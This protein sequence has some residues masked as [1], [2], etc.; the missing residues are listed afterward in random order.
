MKKEHKDA[1]PIAGSSWRELVDLAMQAE[2]P[3]YLGSPRL[4]TAWRGSQIVKARAQDLSALALRI[5]DGFDHRSL[6][7]YA[8]RQMDD[9]AIQ[10]YN[11]A[12]E[13]HAR[14]I[15]AKQQAWLRRKGL[16]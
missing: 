5:L 2:W 16:Q 14:T 13:E 10:E 6:Q 1:A 8:E 7:R 12:A 9:E 15:Q 4:A 3:G 11:K